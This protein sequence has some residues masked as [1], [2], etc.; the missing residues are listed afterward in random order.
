M[1]AYNTY[2]SYTTTVDSV[3]CKEERYADWSSSG[4]GT[5]IVREVDF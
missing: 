2:K 5:K 4:E 3:S 1:M